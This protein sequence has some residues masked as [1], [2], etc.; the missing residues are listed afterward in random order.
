MKKKIEEEFNKYKKTFPNS[1]F[2]KQE[3]FE[4]DTFYNID[5]GNK[6]YFRLHNEWICVKVGNNNA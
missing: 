6:L 3:P 5:D 1:K 2:N 4:G